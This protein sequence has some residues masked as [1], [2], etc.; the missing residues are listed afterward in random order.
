MQHLTVTAVGLERYLASIGHPCKLSRPRKPAH[1][2]IE[3]LS[4]FEVGLMIHD[5]RTLRDKTML[6]V[7]A[8]SAIRNAEFCH[9]EIRDV[10]IA[11]QKIHVRQG[12]GGI[13]RNVNIA[14]PCVQLL[15]DYLRERGGEREDLLFVTR[16]NANEYEPQDLRKF[17]R[18]AARRAGI[19][20]RVHPHLFRHSLA[21]NLVEHGADVF[22]I[23]QQ[24]GHQH[25]STTFRYLHPRAAHAAAQYHSCAPHYAA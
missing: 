23:Q 10:D 15:A 1:K 7:L 22:T 14:G 17:V 9:L 11:A 12:K 2:P 8:Y 20:R 16:R 4:E 6:S 24:L 18:A 13:D 19:T 5:A 3:P 25:L 21:C